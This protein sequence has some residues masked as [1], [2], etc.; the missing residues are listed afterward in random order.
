M[1]DVEKINFEEEIQK[2]NIV[3]KSQRRKSAL[4]PGDMKKLNPLNIFKKD[5]G[6]NIEE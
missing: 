6:G 1:K 5:I 2:L 4:L 3:N